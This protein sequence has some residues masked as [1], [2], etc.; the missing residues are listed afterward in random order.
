MPIYKLAETPVL[1]VQ[2]LRSYGAATFK[3]I[4][5]STFR[6]KFEKKVL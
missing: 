5:T 6:M 2:N 1:P 3:P 4:N